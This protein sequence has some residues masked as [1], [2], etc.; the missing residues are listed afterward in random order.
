L[1]PAVNDDVLMARSVRTLPLA[2]VGGHPEFSPTNEQWKQIE[3]AYGHAL[4]DNV[5]Q[6]IVA[7][8]INFLLFEPFER[9]AEP[10]SLARE[11]VL[12]VQEAA[13]NLHD[14]GEAGGAEGGS[15]GGTTGGGGPEGG[16]VT[17]ALV[18]AK[19]TTATFYAHHLIKQ[20]FADEAYWS[21]KFRGRN[22]DKFVRLRRVLAPLLG[23]ASLRW[24]NWMT[25][26][27]RATVKVNAG[28]DGCG[29]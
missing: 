1:R 9:A 5:R 8:T 6:D 12:T 15:E 20:H 21:R 29:R 22:R 11:R 28:G 2:S 24:R 3:R 14:G 16:A 4:S 10:V 25:R 17:D 18:T 26:T 7:A 13:K 23:A 27:C 19:A